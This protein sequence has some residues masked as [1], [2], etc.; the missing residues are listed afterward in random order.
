MK[1]YPHYLQRLQDATRKYWDKPALNNI[2]GETFTYSQMARH[3]A[4]FH[5]VF[6]YAGIKK[7]DHIAL[8]APNGARWG[9]AYLAVNTYETVIVPIL[10]DFIRGVN[11]FPSQIE[12]VLVRIEGVEPQ[13][14]IIV[15]R[16]DNLDIIE[17]KVEMNDALF[18]DQ[19][20][21]LAATEKYIAGELHN[22]LNIHTKVTLV[23]PKSIPRGDGK[24]K[25]VFD[26]RVLH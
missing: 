26:N 7:G 20:K 5:I 9:F 23:E 4:R 1:E 25:R 12:E 10:A 24:R 2:G 19:M 3:I 15:D 16:K 11:V 18:S 14:Q 17:I 22:M 21:N 8:C 13:Y 6:E